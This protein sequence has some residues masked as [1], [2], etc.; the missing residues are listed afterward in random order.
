[1]KRYRVK[2]TAG[3]NTVMEVL[4]IQPDGYRVRVTRHHP[5]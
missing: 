2:S 1:M 5:D 4:S 3:V